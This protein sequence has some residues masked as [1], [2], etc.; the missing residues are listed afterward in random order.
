MNEFVFRWI[1]RQLHLI[2][3]R[4]FYIKESWREERENY[5]AKPPP[6]GKD[7]RIAVAPQNML[8]DRLAAYRY[9]RYRASVPRYVIERIRKDVTQYQKQKLNGPAGCRKDSKISVAPLPVPASPSRK[10]PSGPA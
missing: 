10:S 1:C 9:R 4:H 2:Q 3:R 5:R 7:L 6:L 8:E